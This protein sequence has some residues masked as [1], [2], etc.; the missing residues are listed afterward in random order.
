MKSNLAEKLL[1]ICGGEAKNYGCNDNYGITRLTEEQRVQ[2]EEQLIKHF[3][4]DKII[5]MEFPSGF[6]EDKT[7]PI[8]A[9]S[10]KI[11]DTDNP[12]YK[13]K[14]GYIYSIQFTSKLYE[15][16]ELHRAVKDGCVITPII[17]NSETFEP[18]Q[19]ITLSLNGEL[20]QDID[21]S[22]R[23]NG[24]KYIISEDDKQTIRDMLEKVLSNPD[25]YTPIGYTGCLLR[26]T[27]V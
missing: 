20:L 13:H 12:I 18:K 8:V 21:G 22:Q 16:G 4:F 24:D 26:Y 2:V 23:T 19:A 5:W 6:T 7:T 9:K 11:S 17:Y 10:I 14:V 1:S 3:E 15:D 27:V 25:E